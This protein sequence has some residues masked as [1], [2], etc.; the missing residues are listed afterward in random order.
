M[1]IRTGD[2]IRVIAGKDKGREG[3]VERVYSKQNKALIP[4][5]NMY[6]RH[7]KKSEQVPDG[8]IVEL[9]RPIDVAKIMYVSTS[10]KKATRLGFIVEGGK[11]FRVDRKTGDR[12][13]KK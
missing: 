1:K 8:G 5:I 11:K 10:T 9:P 12:I 2:K 3:T 13:N 6:K 7:M 4:G